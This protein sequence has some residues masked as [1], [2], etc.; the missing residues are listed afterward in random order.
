VRQLEISKYATQAI[1]ASN[2]KVNATW[3]VGGDCDKSFKSGD[4]RSLQ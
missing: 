3:G 4:K 1:F 2:E